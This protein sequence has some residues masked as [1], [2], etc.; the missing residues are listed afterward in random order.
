MKNPRLEEALAALRGRADGRVRD[1]LRRYAIPS[2]RALGVSMKDVQALGREL[3]RDPALAEAL[4]ASAV[5]EARLLA[6]FVAEPEAMTPAKMDRW[7]RDFDSWALVDTA[8]FKLFDRSPHALGRV[9]AWAGKRGE[10]QRRAGIVLLGCVAAHDKSA[11]DAALL[12]LLPLLEKAATDGRNF[13]KKGLL[14]SLKLLAGR[15]RP[16]VRDAV[17]ALSRRLATSDDPSAAWTGR[18]A[19]RAL[20]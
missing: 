17:R 12:R 9:K 2:E 16:R 18:N 5:Y 20:R 15:G 10:F 1:G 7:C 8:C 4:W 13:V 11:P 14:W 3:G 19:L 6:C